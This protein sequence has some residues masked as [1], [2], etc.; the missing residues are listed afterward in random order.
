MG[1]SRRP[2]RRRPIRSQQSGCAARSLARA[3]PSHGLRPGTRL[4]G[5]RNDD[6]AGDLRDLSTSSRT[7][8]I[9]VGE[10]ERRADAVVRHQRRGRP[11]LGLRNH[12]RRSSRASLV[13]WYEKSEIV[14]YVIECY[15]GVDAGRRQFIWEEP[16]GDIVIGNARAFTDH[17]GEK[18]GVA[19]TPTAWMRVHDVLRALGE[20]VHAAKHDGSRVGKKFKNQE[21]HSH[22]LRRKN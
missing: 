21:P 5:S 8:W 12:G 2:V 3:G 15:A 10:A 20:I 4:R 22:V 14:D 17:V 9:R 13:R 16:N 11:S 6:G 18:F 7:S 19:V 1:D